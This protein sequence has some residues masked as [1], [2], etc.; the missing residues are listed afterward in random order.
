MMKF[1]DVYH[2]K[3]PFYLC[4]Y[5]TFETRDIC[6]N[7]MQLSCERFRFD[8]DTCL[9]VKS[10]QNL[11]ILSRYDRRRE[12]R[13]LYTVFP[14]FNFNLVC[15][16]YVFIPYNTINHV[17]LIAHDSDVLRARILHHVSAIMTFAKDDQRVCIPCSNSFLW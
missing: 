15:V 6:E 13:Y 14:Y 4:K 12:G 2:I 1:G 3:M 17:P 16:L 9:K 11:K 8:T 10:S 7:R 5:I